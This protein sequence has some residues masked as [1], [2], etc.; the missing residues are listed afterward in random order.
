MY[1]RKI[2]RAIVLSAL[3]CFLANVMYAQNKT[4]NGRVTDSL[5]TGV[6]GVT[7]SARNIKAV[8]TTNDGAFTINVPPSVNT[9]IFTSVGFQRQEVTITNNMNITLQNTT[10][11]LNEVVVVGYGTVRK[12]DLT[13]SV[14][15]ITSKDFQKGQISTPEQLIAG[16]VPG[17][18][19]I[20]NGGQPGAG[21]TIRIR[22]GSSLNASNDPLVVIDGVPLDND[23]IPGASNPLSFVNPNDIESFTILKDASAAAI[24]GTRASNG[25]IL[26][27][28]KKGRGGSL[29]LNFSTVNSV[30]TIIKKVDVFDANQFRS[31]VNANGS[32]AQKSMLGK[33][34]TNWQDQIYQNAFATDNNISIS[35]G[36]KKLPYRISLGYQN[37]DGILKTDNLQKGSFA[38]A[39][40]P[41]LFDNHLKIDLNLKGSREQARFANKGAIGG[42]V[43]FDPTQPVYTNSKRYNGYFEWVD[44]SGALSNLAGK[45]PVAQL[46]DR[47]DKGN[48]LRSIGNIQFDYK[49][50]FFPVCMQILI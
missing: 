19:I 22:G 4:V 26:I 31:I 23:N 10:S 44:G 25:V 8:T 9:L 36:I 27:T 33:A 39:L 40:N 1:K 11:N 3:F 7:V 15:T 41:V 47:I 32:D 13:G 17:V 30:S 24:Y 6:P 34:N 50:H 29:K 38:I 37:Q 16:K 46:K 21:S 43:S 2:L 14:A 5:G 28:T 20:S 49:F 12:K 48:P 45:N 18:S 35:G 42:A